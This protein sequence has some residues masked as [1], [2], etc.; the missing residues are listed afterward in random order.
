MVFLHDITR[1]ARGFSLMIRVVSSV[2]SFSFFWIRD[3]PFLGLTVGCAWFG[4]NDVLVGFPLVIVVRV[5]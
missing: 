4:D 3:M 2:F 5:M 1:V